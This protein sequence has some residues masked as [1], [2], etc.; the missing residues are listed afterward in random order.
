MLQEQRE[1]TRGLERVKLEHDLLKEAGQKAREAE[2]EM[3]G[4]LTEVEDYARDL[5]VLTMREQEA[6]RNRVRELSEETEKLNCRWDTASEE[7]STTEVPPH[8]RQWAERE[9]EKMTFLV[10]E[11]VEQE[12]KATGELLRQMGGH[13]KLRGVAKTRFAALLSQLQKPVPEA[14][15]MAI[16]VEF[17]K[18]LEEA[19]ELLEGSPTEQQGMLKLV[20]TSQKKLAPLL[21]ELG[22]VTNAAELRSI[23]LEA[24]GLGMYEDEAKLAT[25]SESMA[26]RLIEGFEYQPFGESIRQ[27]EL[28]LT[29][30]A[31]AEGKLG[32][33]QESVA[34]LAPR[35]YGSGELV[36]TK[37]WWRLRNHLDEVDVHL[38]EAM[39]SP[40]MIDADFATIFRELKRVSTL[41]TQSGRYLL[42]PKLRRAGVHAAT[43]ERTGEEAR[44]K[45]SHVFKEN[46]VMKAA[47]DKPPR[48]M[49]EAR[50]P[51]ERPQRD[52]QPRMEQETRRFNCY[53]CQR[54]GHRAAQCPIELTEEVKRYKASMKAARQKVNP[55]EY[56][57]LCGK[58]YPLIG[59]MPARGE[60]E[61]VQS[62][63][64]R[65]ELLKVFSTPPMAKVYEETSVP[66]EVARVASATV[67]E[68][69]L[70]VELEEWRTELRKM[71]EEARRGSSDEGEGEG[72]E[73][74][75]RHQCATM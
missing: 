37:L 50:Q 11:A 36:R 25:N 47:G 3:R 66:K 46:N 14:P 49:S 21:R 44:P 51:R 45:E 63:A 10:A 17:V 53:N 1:L 2:A 68:R 6:Q 19:Y 43:A 18:G 15:D 42:K 16:V 34:M 60:A 72:V 65:R 31:E 5:R 52:V 8:L 57:A 13:G 12:S 4:K 23:F 59:Q 29:A 54:L 75:P 61:S 27:G 26:T 71:G 67:G 58:V 55:E 38:A 48:Y 20:Q 74:R 64:A 40:P 62:A 70:E 30:L 22:R 9:K 35:L 32:Y 69:W 73:G 24:F 39:A 41:Q 28:T 33:I 56:R 7:A